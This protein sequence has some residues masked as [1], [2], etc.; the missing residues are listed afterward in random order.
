MGP[1]IGLQAGRGAR[2]GKERDAMLG[3]PY[4]PPRHAVL[5]MPCASLYLCVCACKR[6][7][8]CVWCR[9]IKRQYL[10]SHRTTGRHGRAGVILR[11]HGGH[12][13]REHI[14]TRTVHVLR[15]FHRVARKEDTI[16]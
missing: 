15:R 4:V 11:W 14:D 5:A 3:A 2:E 1:K 10:P 8:V 9:F 12:C 7:R 13:I 6:V 16:L